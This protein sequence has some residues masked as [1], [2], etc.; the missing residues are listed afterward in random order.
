MGWWVGWWVGITDL[1][2]IVRVWNMYVLQVPRTPTS[3]GR[4]PTS[5]LSMSKITI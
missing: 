3:V 5:K 2:L 4:H 1:S